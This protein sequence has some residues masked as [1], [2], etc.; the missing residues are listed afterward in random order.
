MVDK[1]FIVTS[2]YKDLIWKLLSE[3]VNYKLLFLLSPYKELYAAFN[4]NTNLFSF[5]NSLFVML[6]K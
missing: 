6:D 3:T 5:R 4:L 1:C 2:R